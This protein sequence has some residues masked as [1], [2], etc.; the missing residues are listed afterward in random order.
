MVTMRPH[1]WRCIQG[2][3][4]RA[5]WI[6]LMKFNSTARC[7]SSVVVARNILAGGPPA[8]V[9]QTSTEL[10][11]LPTCSTK[12]CTA[13]SSVTSSGA[14]MTS[15]EWRWRISSAAAR[16]FDSSREHIAILAP[17]AANFSAAARAIPSLEAATMTLRFLS[18]RSKRVS[19]LQ[20]ESEFAAKI[21][22]VTVDPILTR[23]IEDVEIDGVF[24]CVRF[25]RDIGRNAQDLTG[26]DHNLFAINEKL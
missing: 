13:A 9:T 11:L 6:T 1:C 24:E 18:P 21:R 4:A 12:P 20:G 5:K 17:S 22:V 7:H 10:N 16:S 3:T 14:A 2:M 19:F 23:R 25:V 8:L 26:A 15:T